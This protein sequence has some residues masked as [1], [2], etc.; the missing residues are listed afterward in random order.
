MLLAFLI[1]LHKAVVPVLIA[2]MVLRWLVMG[3]FL[4]MPGLFAGSRSRLFLALFALFYVLHLVG[5]LSTLHLAAGWFDLEVKLTLLIFPLIFITLDAK[6]L[7]TAWLR[8]IMLGFVAGSVLSI[9]LSLGRAAILW[10]ASGDPGVFYY[11]RLS[12]FHH[13]S[14][15]AMYLNFA[16]VICIHFLAI[17]RERSGSFWNTAGIAIVFLFMIG[18]VLLSSKAGILGMALV[19]FLSMAY[20]IIRQRMV[21]RG[22]LWF[23]LSV[24][25]FYVLIHLLP[26]P[27]QRLERAASTVGSAD[28]L[29]STTRE[30]TGERLLVWQASLELIGDHF[31][32]GVGT[33]D[34][35]DELVAIY[36]EKGI[37]AAARDRLNTHNQFLQTQAALGII[38]SLALVLMLFLPLL[39]AIRLDYYLY[40]M[41]LVLFG[42]NILFE[43]MLQTQSGVIF[44]A[45]L[46]VL[47][48]SANRQ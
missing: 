2:L 1:P 36:Q 5:M 34:V 8:N 13:A 32:A 20:L 11:T 33:G 18:V 28:S 23:I 40:G 26:Y 7:D 10:N 30:S 4:R 24:S 27:K 47:L 37:T 14:Y 9:L 16:S 6:V 46:N 41:F 3:E 35:I 45:F 42:F 25:V 44:Y 39:D 38:G 48:F 22:V 31:L 29:Q 43:S 17:D 12:W 15:M 19:L 21:L